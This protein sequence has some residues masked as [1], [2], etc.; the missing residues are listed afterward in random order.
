M[1]ATSM[2]AM[3]GRPY[4]GPGRMR[5]RTSNSRRVPAATQ[6]QA[7]R[8]FIILTIDPCYDIVADMRS[9]SLGA[10]SL[11]RA[12]VPLLRFLDLF[13][14]KQRGTADVAAVPA[15]AKPSAG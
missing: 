11:S 6:W 7:K 1:P 4:G 10:M 5:S 2:S 14:P 12:V 15:S 9:P 3:R 8:A 13:Q